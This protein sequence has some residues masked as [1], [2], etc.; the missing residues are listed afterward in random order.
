M[1]DQPA[2]DPQDEAFIEEAD[3]IGADD[4]DHAE[5]FDAPCWKSA[6]RLAPIQGDNH[7]SC[8][9]A[10]ATSGSSATATTLFSIERW[11]FT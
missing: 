1:D 4:W 8:A 9:L 10:P 6:E 7:S 3:W 11:R 2:L 5:S